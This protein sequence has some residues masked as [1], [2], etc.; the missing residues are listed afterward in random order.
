MKVRSQTTTNNWP[1]WFSVICWARAFCVT[2]NTKRTEKNQNGFAPSAWMKKST[3]FTQQNAFM[4][5]WNCRQRACNQQMKNQW[6]LIAIA[7]AKTIYSIFIRITRVPYEIVDAT[8]VNLKRH[9]K[10]NWRRIG[11]A[12][13]F[14][15]EQ[16]STRKKKQ[17]SIKLRWRRRWKIKITSNFA[18]SSICLWIEMNEN[19]AKREKINYIKWIAFVGINLWILLQISIIFFIANARY[20]WKMINDRMEKVVNYF[21]FVSAAGVAVHSGKQKGPMVHSFYAIFCQS[22]STRS[23]L[24]ETF[25][26]RKYCQLST[27]Q[28]DHKI[29]AK[30]NAKEMEIEKRKIKSE[31]R[32]ERKFFFFI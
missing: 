30:L 2:K 1:F 9:Q 13:S 11:I 21:F 7:Q 14:G 23:S 16:N 3:E 20:D 27:A 5:R 18:P 26:D 10:D 6:V 31:W 19:A 24:G 22:L 15:C 28:I 25:N 29:H 4:H 32:T 12:V 8:F 17:N